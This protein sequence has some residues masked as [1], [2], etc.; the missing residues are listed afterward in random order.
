MST[1]APAAPAP[2]TSGMTSAPNALSTHPSEAQPAGFGPGIDRSTRIRH[3]LTISALMFA[4][5]FTTTRAVT[6]R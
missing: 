6:P 5:P 2:K 3:N 4:A 1:N